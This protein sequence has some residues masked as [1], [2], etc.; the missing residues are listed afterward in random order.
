MA[1][2]IIRETGAVILAAGVSSISKT[3][4]LRTELDTLRKTGIS[5]IVVVTGYEEASVQRELAHRRVVF[6]SNPRFQETT[7]F[8]SLKLGLQALPEACG[9]V[10]VING[11]TP[12]FSVETLD[13]IRNGTAE[14]VV[15]S[16][17]GMTGHPFCL[18]QSGIR[19][20]LSYRGAGG[21]RGMIQSGHLKTETVP[22]EDPGIHL[23]ADATEG[24][25]EALRYQRETVT[26]NPIR[27][28]LQIGLARKDVF[29]GEELAR[30][31]EEIG[32]C[33]SMNMAARSLGMSYSRGWKMVK[34]AEEMLGYPLIRKQTGGQQGG[35]SSLTDE[36]QTCLCIYRKIQEELQ[37]AAQRALT[38]F[39]V[40]QE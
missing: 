10:L 31:L 15:P 3:G 13:A 37:E 1:Q 21:I 25:Q 36:G 39:P 32:R 8:E 29:F 9:K 33:G 12:S 7:M 5:S 34:H 35:G 17:R 38:R 11:D 28:D 26:A 18:N 16:Y 2:K 30:L 14:M 27:M 19:K 23:E 4:M 22:V 20:I 6:V 40:N 24:L